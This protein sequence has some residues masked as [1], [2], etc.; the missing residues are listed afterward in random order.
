M[1]VDG[2]TE[3]HGIWQHIAVSFLRRYF[4]G[5]DSARLIKLYSVGQLSRLDGTG[6][7]LEWNKAKVRNLTS[8]EIWPKP[9]KHRAATISATVK[10]SE[11]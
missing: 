2:G 11:N 7:M 10:L 5:G 8:A 9:G 6:L 3:H 1:T 4:C